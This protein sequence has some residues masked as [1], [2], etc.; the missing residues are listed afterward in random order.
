MHQTISMMGTPHVQPKA[1][2]SGTY[3]VKP[4]KRQAPNKLL[5]L[6]V[7]LVRYSIYRNKKLTKT[8]LYFI[9][10]KI[11]IDKPILSASV[12]VLIQPKRQPTFQVC[13]SVPRISHDPENETAKR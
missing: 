4:L 10:V 7:V 11:C 8:I 6:K 5:L 1:M 9:T 13:S 12:C 3:E 2:E